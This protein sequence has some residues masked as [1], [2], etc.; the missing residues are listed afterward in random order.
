[1]KYEI[2]INERVIVTTVSYKVAKNI[3]DW[4]KGNKYLFNIN[5]IELI[6]EK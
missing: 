5:K 2:K 1:M 3:F 6:A 4:Y